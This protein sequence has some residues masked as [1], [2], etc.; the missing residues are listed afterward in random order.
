MA[1]HRKF[2]KLSNAEIAAFCRQMAMVLQAGISSLEGIAILRDEAESKE[3]AEILTLIYNALAETGQLSEALEAPDV[4]PPYFLRMCRIGEQAGKLDRV[5]CSLASFYEREAGIAEAVRSAVTYPMVMLVMMLIVV[6]VL[7]ARVLPVFHQ[8]FSQLGSEM[9]LAS[10]SLI[11]F[12]SFL[13]RYGLVFVIILLALIAL[14]LYLTRTRKGQA[15]LALLGERFP[16]SRRFS[17]LTASC[18]FAGG[19]SLL[20]SSGFSPEESISMASEL[21]EGERFRE[22]LNICREKLDAGEDMSEAFTHAGIFTGV[23]GRMMLVAQ[24][25][26]TLDEALQDIASRCEDELDDRLARAMS[27]LEPTLVAVLSIVTGVILL[28]VMLPLMGIL[29]GM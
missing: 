13:N 5:M 28:S 7:V 6:A 27:V 17:D 3:D 26:G 14:V 25:T 20:L 2:K 15:A 22:K 23:Y 29:S 18:R 12:G 19:L 16:F 8:V 11:Q 9:N 24:K 1:E 4:F 10:R 21:T